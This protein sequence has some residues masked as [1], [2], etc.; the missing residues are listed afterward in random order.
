MIACVTHIP[1]FTSTTWLQSTGN[2]ASTTD[3]VLLS[4]AFKLFKQKCLDVLGGHQS[5]TVVLEQEE[6]RSFL[7]G[8]FMMTALL[9]SLYYESLDK[10]LMLNLA[11]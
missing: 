11:F 4:F 3:E 8:I 7:F 10:A 6:D 5:D 2:T 1:S 9:S